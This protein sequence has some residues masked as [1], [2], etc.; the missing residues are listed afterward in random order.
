MYIAVNA[1]LQPQITSG[2]L[3]ESLKPDASDIEFTRFGDIPNRSPA[4]NT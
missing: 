1:A 4:T 3:W 2:Q